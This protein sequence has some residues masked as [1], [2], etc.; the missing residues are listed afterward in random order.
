[1]IG[2][3]LCGRPREQWQQYIAGKAAE[4]GEDPTAVLHEAIRPSYLALR[5]P[6]KRCFL[7][8]AAFREGESIHAGDLLDIW[9]GWELV[10]CSHAYVAAKSYLQE[11][12]DACLIH[13]EG[14]ESFTCIDLLESRIHEARFYMHDVLWDLAGRLALGQTSITGEWGDVNWPFFIMEVHFFQSI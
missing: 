13:R 14:T 6:V 4:T 8:F 2:R 9:A 10:A 7:T 11:L 1:V 5:L 12:E 3:Y